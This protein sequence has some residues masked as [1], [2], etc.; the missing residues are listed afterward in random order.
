MNSKLFI[1][2]TTSNEVEHRYQELSEVFKNQEEMIHVIDEEY[3]IIRSILDVPKPV[4]VAKENATTVSDIIQILQKKVNPEGLH[5]QICGSWLWLS[6]K[7]FRVKDTLKELGFRYSKDK[8]SWYWRGED[9]R[10]GNFEPVPFELIKEK[11]GS[12]EVTLR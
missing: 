6:G 7:T 2:C 11:Y 1:G 8:L 12:K 4:E 10:S 5:L 3:S 9:Q